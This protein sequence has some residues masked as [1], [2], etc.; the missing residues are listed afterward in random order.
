[1]KKLYSAVFAG[2]I[3]LAAS[4]ASAAVL[5][6]PNPVL[7]DPRD[8]YV[9]LTTPASL[10]ATCYDFGTL[11][12]GNG[13]PDFVNS[14]TVILDNDKLELPTGTSTTAL[15]DSGGAGGV[16]SGFVDNSLSGSVTFLKNATVPLF[17]Y[18]KFGGGQNDPYWF[19][20]RLTGVNAN[21]SVSWML[22]ETN[23]TQ[24]NGLSGI[25]VFGEVTDGPCVN[26]AAG[27]CNVP[28]RPSVAEPATL[29]LLGIGLLGAGAARRRRR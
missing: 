14:N 9:E 27:G 24:F 2:A 29:A 22:K 1:M 10:S 28:D 4:S 18:F 13:T 26:P 12:G 17:L 19:A 8:T 15:Q 21:E 25:R 23:G 20:F 3:S 5:T 6:C 11:G 7:P 16:F